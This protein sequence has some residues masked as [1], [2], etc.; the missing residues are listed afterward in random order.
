M[1]LL[2]R[3]EGFRTPKYSRVQRSDETYR[4][5]ARYV[6]A[7][8]ERLIQL[9]DATRNDEQTSR[10]IR[11]DVDNALR[12]YHQYCIKERIG[13][14]YVELGIEGN[15]IFEHM[16]PASRIRDLLLVGRITAHEACNAP[17]CK[18][19][20]ASDQLLKDRGWNSDTPSLTDFWRRYRLCFPTQGRFET[21][22]GTAV[23]TETWTLDKHYAYFIN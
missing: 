18:L 15:G 21:H 16:I 22:D 14:H 3:L 19:S 13:A 4:A 6:T 7:N 20:V 17:T 11:D 12:R 5:T 1:T 10:L 23:D 9:Y 8:L 2:E